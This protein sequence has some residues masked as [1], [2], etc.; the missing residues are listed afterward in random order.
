M[1]M[2]FALL[3]TGR[4]SFAQGSYVAILLNTVNSTLN[5][6]DM[7]SALKGFKKDIR[8][9]QAG[10]S[11]QAGVTNNFSI[12]T[13][14]YFVKKGGI[15][16]AGNPLTGGK[17]SLKLYTAEVPIL[18][19]LHA[20]KFYFDAGPYANYMFSGKRTAEGEGSHSLSFGQG[21]D[22]FRRWETGL[23]GGA[24]YHFTLKKARMAIDLRYTHGLTSIS[25]GDHL[26]H[27]T[28]NLNLLVLRSRKSQG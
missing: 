24:G 20:R 4:T 15:L 1:T 3:A 11:W 5:Y 27:R 2:V 22:A 18:A 26:Y 10:L 23:Q 19:R 14:A 21:P 7:N 9:I 6:G 17:S 16:K 12:V 25:K 28:I 13:E 8:G